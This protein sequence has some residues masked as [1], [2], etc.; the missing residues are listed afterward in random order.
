[1][2]FHDSGMNFQCVIDRNIPTLRAFI[3]HVLTH[4]DTKLCNFT[5]FWMVNA[6]TIELIS[7]FLK[8]FVRYIIGLFVIITTYGCSLALF[9]L[10]P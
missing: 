8:I 7:I 2:P 10:V 3:C 6:I 5:D 1:M 9:Y 4:F